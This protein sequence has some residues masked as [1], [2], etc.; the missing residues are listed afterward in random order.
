MHLAGKTQPG[1]DCVS[2][3]SLDGLYKD[4]GWLKFL[5]MVNLILG[6]LMSLPVLTLVVTWVMI[7]VGLM[8]ISAADQFKKGYE[9]RDL[10]FARSGIEELAK[11]IRVTSILSVV[12]MALFVLLL[13][14]GILV[15]ILTPAL[16]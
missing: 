1:A 2:W 15:L 5:G 3:Q 16:I 11:L 4:I 7:W 8:A 13:L 9:S 12:T 10:Y 6:I 14:I